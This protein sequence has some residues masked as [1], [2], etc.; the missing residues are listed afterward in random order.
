MKAEA[1]GQDLHTGLDGKDAQEVRFS[2]FELQRQWCPITT[3][4]VLFKSQHHTV[5]QN[6][7]CPKLLRHVVHFAHQASMW[8]YL[9]Y[10]SYDMIAMHQ[11]VKIPFGVSRFPRAFIS[12]C[13]ESESPLLGYSIELLPLFRHCLSCLLPI[14]PTS[15]RY[16]HL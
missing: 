5:R 6:G 15:R 11:M 4:Q 12:H 9:S 14:L 2:L 3:G 16:Q 10:L 13:P 7:T 1:V 8:R